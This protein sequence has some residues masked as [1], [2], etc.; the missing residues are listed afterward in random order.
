MSVNGRLAGRSV[1][2]S[3]THQIACLLHHAQGIYI[4]GVG[5]GYS[6]LCT[7]PTKL[8]QEAVHFALFHFLNRTFHC[9]VRRWRSWT[10][11]PTTSSSTPSGNNKSFHANGH[12]YRMSQRSINP[13]RSNH[14]FTF[15]FTTP[16]KICLGAKRSLQI[17]LFV[18]PYARMLSVCPSSF[19]I[20]YL[21][22]FSLRETKW[23][24]SILQPT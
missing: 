15:P 9:R 5:G 24:D 8:E 11:W 20:L 13:C 7:S 6:T 17:S 16:R 12:V 14:L 10:S 19:V 21:D 2:L 22:L 23:A 18:R 3:C 4:Y 1:C